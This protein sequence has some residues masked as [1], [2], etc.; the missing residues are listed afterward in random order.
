MSEQYYK[1]VFAA[2]LGANFVNE[3]VSEWQIDA[4]KESI[5]RYSEAVIDHSQLSYLEKEEHKKQMKL[6]LKEGN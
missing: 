1:G 3:P 2:Y 6:S 4:I 5:S